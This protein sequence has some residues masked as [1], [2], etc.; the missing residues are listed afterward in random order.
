MHY[1]LLAMLTLVSQCGNA[2]AWGNKVYKIVCE[3][4]CH[5]STVARVTRDD[6]GGNDITI[7]GACSGKLHSTRDTCLVEN[8]VGTDVD[9][10]VDELIDATTPEMEDQVER[11]RPGMGKR[12]IC[13]RGGGQ[14][15]LLCDAWSIV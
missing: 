11:F 4:A 15:R 2:H 3:I 14:N 13:Y 5:P 8:A 12:V 7:S 10:A 9:D 1:I 6:R